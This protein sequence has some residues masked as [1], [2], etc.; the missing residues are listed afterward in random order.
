MTRVLTLRCRLEWSLGRLAHP[1][2]GRLVRELGSRGG[3]G[4][5]FI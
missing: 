1:F 3:P 2:P 4:S 5:F